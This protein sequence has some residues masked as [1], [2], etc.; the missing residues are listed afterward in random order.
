M[1]RHLDRHFP[2]PDADQAELILE[3]WATKKFDTIE[4]GRLVC[5]H[6]S[7][8]SRTI[9]AARDMLR[10]LYREAQS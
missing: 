3:L 4:I 6:E 5:L 9:H 8:V 1:T 10:M 7:V 2:A